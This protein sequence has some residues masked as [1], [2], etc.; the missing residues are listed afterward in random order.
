MLFNH[1]WSTLRLLGGLLWPAAGRDVKKLKIFNDLLIFL[2]FVFK[3]KHL[4]L[5]GPCGFFYL[6]VDK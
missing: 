3:V 4:P 2:T 5:A 6:F 1:P